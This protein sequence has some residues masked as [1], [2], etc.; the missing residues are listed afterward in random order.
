[1]HV[2][3]HVQYIIIAALLLFLFHDHQQQSNVIHVRKSTFMSL[4]IFMVY[5]YGL[6]C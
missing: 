6:N 3:V 5:Y 1:M 4:T 2:H